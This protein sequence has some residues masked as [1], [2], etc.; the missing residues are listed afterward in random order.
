MRLT[1]RYPHRKKLL[2]RWND[3]WHR[4]VLIARLLCVIAAS[5]LFISCAQ[6]TSELGLSTQ[7]WHLSLYL[8]L[9]FLLVVIVPIHVAHLYADKVSMSISP[10]FCIVTYATTPFIY[11][12]LWMDEKLRSRSQINTEDSP[13]TEDE[14][15]H[16]INAQLMMN[17]KMKSGDHTK[18]FEFGDT[19]VREITPARRYCGH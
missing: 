7:I 17:S 5:L 16:L 3:Q 18:V 6:I 15:I 11:P 8:I 10:I 19:V 13:S 4:V 9:Y 2:I 1:E 12:L 14:V